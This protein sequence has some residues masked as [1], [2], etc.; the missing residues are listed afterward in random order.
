MDLE[1]V[2]QVA[3][4]LQSAVAVPVSLNATRLHLTCSVG[5]CLADRAPEASGQALLEAALMAADEAAAQGPGAI[6]AY[7]PEISQRRANRSALR[8]ELETALDEG[9]IR[10]CLLYTSRCV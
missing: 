6:R 4:R 1:T 3:A 10:P 5:F 8:D 7:S 2:V 9:Q